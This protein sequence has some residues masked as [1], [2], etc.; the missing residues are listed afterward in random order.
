[1]NVKGGRVDG[2]HCTSL[3]GRYVVENQG[4]PGEGWKVEADVLKEAGRH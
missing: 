1:M 2:I 3:A 4:V